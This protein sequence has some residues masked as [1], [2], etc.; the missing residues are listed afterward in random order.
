MI[1]PSI[2]ST[3]REQRAFFGRMQMAVL[4]PS[5]LHNRNPEA[6]AIGFASLA[7]LPA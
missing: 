3:K 7:G 5:F 1:W 4:S 6:Q 2:G